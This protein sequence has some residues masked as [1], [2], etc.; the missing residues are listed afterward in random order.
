[1]YKLAKGRKSSIRYPKDGNGKKKIHRREK[2]RK[3]RGEVG[4]FFI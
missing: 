1:M 4:N 3:G 2:L